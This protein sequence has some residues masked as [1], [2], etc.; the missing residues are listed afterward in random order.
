MRYAQ[1]G[2]QEEGRFFGNAV[3]VK[4]H[5]VNIWELFREVYTKNKHTP[6]TLMTA[7]MTSRTVTF[8]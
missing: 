1:T 2:K 8:W 3:N 6:T 4:V 7:P 5:K